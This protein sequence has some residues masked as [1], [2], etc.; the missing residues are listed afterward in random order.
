[1][2]A[3]YFYTGGPVPI[4]YTPF[5]ELVSGAFMGLGI[6]LISFYIQTGTLTSKAVLVSLPI[7]IL[8]IHLTVEQYP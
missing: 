6:I 4:A 2:A 1:M 7:S 3:G 5:G 8:V